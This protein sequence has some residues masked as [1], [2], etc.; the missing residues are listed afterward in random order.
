MTHIKR[1]N[2][3]DYLEISNNTSTI[4]ITLQGAHI[5][6]FKVKDKKPL[7][8]LSKNAKFE[9]A[10]PIRGGV[11]ICWPWFGPHPTNKNLPNHGFARISLWEHIDTQEI[12]KDKTKIIL[13]LKSSQQTLALWPYNFELNLEVYMSDVLE[14]HLITKNM[15]AKAFVLSQAL[16]TY[17]LIDDLHTAKIKGLQNCKYYN[18]VDDTYANTQEGTLTFTQ[19][20]DRVY[21]GV[22]NTLEVEDIKVKTLGSKTVVVWNP[23]EELIKK[24]PD[25][26]SYEDMLCIESASTLKD[27]LT[28]QAGQ[29]HTLKS[30]I[31]QKP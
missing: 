14:L 5:F 22:E 27:T 3:L 4:K 16:H 26:S 20:V 13:R 15:D 1:Q 7:L 18:K 25:L 8:Y 29:S 9:K 17:L 6:D 10:F 2:R 28:L 11:P 31:S 19:E 24:I 30:I 23:A 21:Q 12:T